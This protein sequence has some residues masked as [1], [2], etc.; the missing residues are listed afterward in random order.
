[1][2]HGAYNV[3]LTVNF[4]HEFVADIFKTFAA[5][6]RGISPVKVGVSR[7]RLRVQFQ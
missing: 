5:D 4:M 6:T 2:M 3:K 1:M 7:E